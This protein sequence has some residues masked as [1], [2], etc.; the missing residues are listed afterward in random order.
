[1]HDLLLCSKRSFAPRVFTFNNILCINTCSGCG[2]VFIGN[3]YSV[4]CHTH[5][6]HILSSVIFVS[7]IFCHLSYSY[8]S[9]SVICHIRIP[10]ILSSVIFFLVNRDT[11]TSFKTTDECYPSSPFVHLKVLE[12]STFKW[13]QLEDGG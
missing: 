10:H 12:I 3:S 6:P 1:M 11:S 8:P 4:T 2:H 7:L 5:I 13:D 9:Y